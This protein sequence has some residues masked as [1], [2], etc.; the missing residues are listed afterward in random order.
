V[1][2]ASNGAHH[3]QYAFAPISIVQLGQHA[4]PH[5]VQAIEPVPW[6]RVIPQ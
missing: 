5:S 2:G 1:A 3:R 4:A 6:T